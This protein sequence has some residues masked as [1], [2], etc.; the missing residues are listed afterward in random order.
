M[1]QA[2]KLYA[3]WCDKYPNSVW[4]KYDSNHMKLIINVQEGLNQD[5]ITGFLDG[6]GFDPLKPGITWQVKDDYCFDDSNEVH[7]LEL[8]ATKGYVM[9]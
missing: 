4:V 1:V 7:V 9:V 3:K 8:C 6:E 2:H 5:E